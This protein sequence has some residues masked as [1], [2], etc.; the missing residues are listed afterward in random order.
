MDKLGIDGSIFISAR[1]RSRG[2][3]APGFDRILRADVRYDF[4][5]ALI[6]VRRAPT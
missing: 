6:S 1:R 5:R 2:A 3:T 4:H